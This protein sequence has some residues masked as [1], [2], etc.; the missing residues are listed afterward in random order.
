MTDMLAA[1]SWLSHLICATWGCLFETPSSNSETRT[2]T[3]ALLKAAEDNT[4]EVV[5]LPKWDTAKRH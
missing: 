5:S 4:R 1:A 2:L 3:P